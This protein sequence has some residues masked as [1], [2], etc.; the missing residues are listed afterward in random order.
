MP[1]AEN[2]STLTVA[3]LLNAA[4]AYPQVHAAIAGFC[5]LAAVPA[6]LREHVRQALLA[7]ENNPLRA[8]MGATAEGRW[9]PEPLAEAAVVAMLAAS[10]PL[11]EIAQRRSPRR[12]PADRQGSARRPPRRRRRGDRPPPRQRP[13][14]C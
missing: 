2:T 8:L 13:P 6:E 9:T 1:A 3:D 14:H 12:P 11:R 4:R 5:V 7:S 10:G